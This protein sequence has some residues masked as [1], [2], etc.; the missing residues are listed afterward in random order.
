MKTQPNNSFLIIMVSMV[1]VIGS[2]LGVVAN[3]AGFFN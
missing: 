1:V 3:A 2:T